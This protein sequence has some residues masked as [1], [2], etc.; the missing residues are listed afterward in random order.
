MLAEDRVRLHHMAEADESAMSV[1]SECSLVQ[2]LR[3][4]YNRWAHQH[5]ISTDATY[6][7]LDSAAR[8]LMAVSAPQ[9]DDIDRMKQGRQLDTKIQPGPGGT[10]TTTD[11]RRRRCLTNP[12]CPG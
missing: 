7:A 11:R 5:T 3:E 12:I 8:L 2:A 9:A 10:A 4:V 1:A 6:R